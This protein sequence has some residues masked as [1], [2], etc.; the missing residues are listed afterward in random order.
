MK[1]NKQIAIG[2]LT[3]L[4]AGSV[5]A[6]DA[7]IE[8]S[9]LVN[10]LSLASAVQAAQ[11][12]ISTCR[13][14]GYQVSASVVDSFGQIQVVL[15]DTSASVISVELSKKK[16]ATAANFRKNTTQIADLSD[17]AVGRSE[18]V[19]MSAGGVLIK[20]DEV[21]YGAVGVSG[22]FGGATDDTCAAAGA[23]AII[24]ALKKDKEKAK[25]ETK[26]EE[27]AAKTESKK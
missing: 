11:V 14:N 23:D 25:A 22:S 24:E 8:N 13:K 9:V 5:V 26:V 12:S 4:L 7:G 10:Q 15:R 27:A 18:G 16:A 17:T 19:L 2:V 3:A 1:N 6:D 21:I 20:L